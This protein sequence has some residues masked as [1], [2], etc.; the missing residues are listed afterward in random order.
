M[1]IIVESPYRCTFIHSPKNGGN[2]IAKWL[3][4]NMH[5]AAVT[6]RKQHA[7]VQTVINGG[8]SLGPINYADLGLI[9]GVVRNPWSFAVSWYTFKIGLCELYIKN[10]EDNPNLIG[11]THSHKF[12]WEYNHQRLKDL[13]AMGFLGW[14]KK[15]NVRPQIYWAKDYHYVM[16]LETLDT[17]FKFIQHKLGCYAPL[18]RE[19]VT[20]R[21]KHWKEYYT[22]QEAID[23]VATK[24]KE[25]VMAFGYDFG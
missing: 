22:E 2:S 7:T 13:H 6:K 5:H 3:L 1:A 11:K 14:L 25:D 18:T 17:D 12:N 21:K 9:Y 10:M 23:L 20:P 4:N 24:Y 15:T 19:N 16:R 8:H